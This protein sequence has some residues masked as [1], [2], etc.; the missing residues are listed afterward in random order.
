MAKYKA[1]K[2]FSGIISMK[3]GD[4]REINDEELAKDLLQAGF[5]IALES[6][7]KMT[8]KKTAKKSS[9]KDEDGDSN[10]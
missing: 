6:E 3:K 10:G 5:V 2:S 9:K 8:A 4:E 7:E 1:T